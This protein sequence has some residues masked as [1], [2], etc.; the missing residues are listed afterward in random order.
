MPRLRRAKNQLFPRARRFFARFR[1][2]TNAPFSQGN[3]LTLYRQGGEFFPAFF[4]TLEQAKRT[5]CLEFYQVRD[6]RVG[7]QLAEILLAAVRRGVQ[8]YLLYDYVGSFETPGSFFRT[9]ERG[10]VRCLA[11]N[12]P[13]FRRGLAWFDKRDHRKIAVIDGCV[14]FTGGLNIGEEY[15]GFGDCPYRWRD[16]GIRLEGPAVDELQRLFR[17]NWPDESGTFGPGCYDTLGLAQEEETDEVMIVSG[18][19]HHNRSQIRAAFRM[20]IG[21]ATSSIM[22]ETPYF[23]PGPRLLRALL[24]AAR[25]GVA[26]QLILPACNDVP[27]VRLVSRSLYAPLLKGGIQIFERQGTVLH[28][29]VMLVDYAWAIIGSANLDL[30]SFHRNYEVNVIVASQEFGEQVADMIADDLDRSRPIV[31]EE[32]EQ[33]GALVRLLERLGMTISW[34]L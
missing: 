5:I 16:V 4:A 12:P 22:I 30:R 13:P 11:F 14:A 15:A 28:A 26:V 17:E 6:D 31:L 1:R 34:F 25:R 18:G 32:H 27:L 8:V 20:A 2:N 9:L 33:R 24:R 10:G 7:R 19:P 3:R 29:K 21:G 23:V